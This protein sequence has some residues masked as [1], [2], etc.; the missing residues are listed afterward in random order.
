MTCGF[1]HMP[2]TYATMDDVELNHSFFCPLCGEKQQA[3]HK[4]EGVN[5]D[6]MGNGSYT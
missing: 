1:C 3:E 6:E 5:G 4:R 2:W